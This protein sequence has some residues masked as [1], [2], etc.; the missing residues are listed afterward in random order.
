MDLAGKVLNTIPG[1]TYTGV[2]LSSEIPGDFYEFQK[3]Q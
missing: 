1:G 2:R 3:V